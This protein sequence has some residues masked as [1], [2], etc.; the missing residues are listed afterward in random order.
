MQWHLFL[1]SYFS[2]SLLHLLM[3]PCDGNWTDLRLG[4]DSS[5]RDAECV[6]KE[7]SPSPSHPKWPIELT[8]AGLSYFYYKLFSHTLSGPLFA[9]LLSYCGAWF[10]PSTAVVMALSCVF[11]PLASVGQLQDSHSAFTSQFF[12][13]VEFGWRKQL[14]DEWKD[15]LQIRK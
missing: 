3:L 6:R 10:A 9:Q 4:A 2:P 1:S 12:S 7:W 13:A 11:P 8:Q 15:K 14:Q 5:H